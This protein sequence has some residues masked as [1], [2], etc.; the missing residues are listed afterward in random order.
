MA[1][2]DLKCVPCG[3][4]VPALNADQILRL[5]ADTPA[6]SVIGDHHIQRTFQSADFKTALELVNRIG[7][8]AEEEGHHPDIGLAWGKVE[9]TIWTHKIDGLT[10]SDFILA[11]KI[12]RVAAA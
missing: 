8:I 3:G 9:V 2:A 7:A 10:Q 4:G 1:L 11:A 5:K 6:W 12:D